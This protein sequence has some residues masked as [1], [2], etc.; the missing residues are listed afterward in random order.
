MT[1]TQEKYAYAVATVRIKEKTLLSNDFLEQLLSTRTYKDVRRQLVEHG[2]L[3][4]DS[5]DDDD[6]LQK[7]LI[8]SWSLLNEITPLPGLL[9]ALILKNDFHNLKAILKCRFTNTSPD[10]YLIRPCLYDTEEIMNLVSD[11]QYDNLPHPNMCEAAR[12]A[13]DV[14]VRTHDGQYTD[15]MVDCAALAAICDSGSH[16]ESQ[17][18]Q[19]ASELLCVSANVKTA[20]RAC[21]TNKNEHFL[22]TALCECRTLDKEALISA[23][24]AGEEAIQEYLGSTPYDGAAQTLGKGENGEFSL[25]AFEKWFDDGLMER[26]QTAKSIF[27]GPEPL[28]AYYIACETEL[29]NIRILLSGKRHGMDDAVIRERMRKLYV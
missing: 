14:F 15:I 17:L 21:R 26:V 11:K 13:Y 5:G 1:L 20:V 25:S 6:R 9:D 24:L 8:D 12:Q 7:R 16:S 22:D 2:W 19:Y 10:H 28:A 4:V 18:V 27:L 3:S 23:A 29:R